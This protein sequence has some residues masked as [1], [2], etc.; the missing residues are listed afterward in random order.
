MGAT[1]K[2]TPY[3]V[4]RAKQAGVFQFETKEVPKLSEQQ[5]DRLVNSLHSTHKLKDSS[6]REQNQG[7]AHELGGLSFRP[8]MNPVSMVLASTMKSLQQRL[9]GMINKRNQALQKK[10]D[11]REKTE[12][13]EC[14]FAPNREGAKTSEKYL[15]KI[16]REKVSP[17]DFLQY[18]EEKLRRNE[19]RKL[20]IEEIDSRE[21][22]FKPQLNQRSIKMQSKMQAERK[23]EVDPISR[24]TISTP[25][26]RAGKTH[27]S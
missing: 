15:K 11:E 23:I 26:R 14:T 13:A 21:L 8:Q 18:Q 20:I 2:P 1:D 25:K 24:Q 5:W 17:D 16:G 4:W 27:F 19:Q 12:M 10:R 22:T 9:P 3:E 7:L 6:T